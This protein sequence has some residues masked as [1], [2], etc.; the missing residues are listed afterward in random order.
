MSWAPTRS[1]P[2]TCCCWPATRMARRRSSPSGL[3]RLRADPPGDPAAGVAA[4]MAKSYA[5][6]AAVGIAGQA[7]QLHGGMGYTWESGIHVFLKRSALN[8]SLSGSPPVAPGPA[9]PRGL[10]WCGQATAPGSQAGTV[11]AGAE[12][13]RSTMA[14]A[15]TRYPTNASPGLPQTALTAARQRADA[16]DHETV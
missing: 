2:A 7:M 15:W 8:R 14:A 12:I 9:L 5:C 3:A 1:R 16:D 6:A 13:P 11:P 4:S 10:A